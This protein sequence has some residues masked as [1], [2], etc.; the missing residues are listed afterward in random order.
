DL[1]GASNLF[2]DLLY[3]PARLHS[4]YPTL[5]PD[6]DAYDKAA[7]FDFPPD[8]RAALVEALRE[9]NARNPSLD[10]LAKPGTVAVVTG[11]Q[12][13]LFSGP[14]YTVYKALT[15]ARLANQLNSQGIPAVPVFWVATEDHD[16]AEVNHCFVYNG[17][18][19]PVRIDVE[20]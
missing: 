11:Q 14:A 8:R 10:L 18:Y 13:G 1:P 7:K 19:E 16:F 12:V 3:N 5:A 4:F 9:G 6:P 15:A 2:L 17:S 20:G